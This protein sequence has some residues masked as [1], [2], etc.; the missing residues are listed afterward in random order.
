MLVGDMEVVSDPALKALLGKDGWT[1]YYPLGP[2]DPDYSVLR[3][4]ARQGDYYHS[5]EK[6]S[7]DV[8]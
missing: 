3:F 7:F 8:D 4:R 6:K 5:L 2:S 1:K